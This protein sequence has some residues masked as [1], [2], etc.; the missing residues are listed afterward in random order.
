VGNEG[1]AGIPLILLGADEMVVR[2][3]VQVA[4]NAVRMKGRCIQ[5]ACPE[6]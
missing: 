6:W 5:N 2:L 4:G 1:M 3:I